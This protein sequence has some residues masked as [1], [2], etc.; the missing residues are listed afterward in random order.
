MA[1]AMSTDEAKAR[2]RHAAEELKPSAMLTH[3]IADI[4]LWKAAVAGL[5]VSV[6]PRRILI[7][8]LRKAFALMHL[9]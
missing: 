7:G 4:P 2:L 8:T 1:G 9:I 6:V 3:S 5:V